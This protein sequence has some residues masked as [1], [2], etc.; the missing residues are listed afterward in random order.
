MAAGKV[1]N[2]SS[3]GEAVWGLLLGFPVLMG[4]CFIALA[5]MEACR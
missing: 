3:F 4:L 1:T 5:V 2:T